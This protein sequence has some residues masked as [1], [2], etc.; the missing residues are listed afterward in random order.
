MDSH[1]N[2]GL[3]WP[4]D[5]LVAR[6]AAGVDRDAFY[7]SGRQSVRDLEAVLATVE[8]L[9]SSYGDILD[10]GCGCGRIMLWLKELAATSALYGV[11]VDARAIRWAQENLPWATF[12]VNGLLPPLDFA[13]QSFDLVYN[14]SV[15]THL[16]EDHQDQ[17]LAELWRVT[18]PGGHLVLS[19]HGEAPL[20]L[21]EKASANAGGDPSHLRDELN[22]D[23]IAFVERD[24]FTGG[25][26]AADYHSTYHAPWYVF[27]HWSRY[28][29]VRAYLPRRSLGYQDFVLLE[30][31]ASDTA[32]PVAGPRRPTRRATIAGPQA[33]SSAG[34][35]LRP[36]VARALA[37]PLDGPAMDGPAR[38]GAGTRLA[39]KAARR[40][41]D[42]YANY[43]RGVDQDLRDA[44]AALDAA[45]S[46][47]SAQLDDLR[48][49][50][51]VDGVLTLQE[52][53]ARLW[54]SM[55]RQGE[56]VN[57][58]EADLWTA[59]ETSRPAAP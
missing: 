3:P 21:F 56:R 14:H 36:E 23:G 57:R 42:N 6:V 18:R 55:G 48:R 59:I 43:Q 8:R 41:L 25:P 37:R 45:V 29:D 30:R 4:G 58:L 1:D 10:F 27:E 13:D 50:I 33:T 38:Y 11:D 22:R 16:D 20:E 5:E 52:S 49:S 39:R 12:E 34:P 51:R 47:L 19:V 24:A 53:N 54:D 7:E 35:S 15:F 31:R 46:D 17:W 40:L 26:H 9:P 28:F 32:V 44:V 2:A